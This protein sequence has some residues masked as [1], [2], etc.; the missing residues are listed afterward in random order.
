MEMSRKLMAIALVSAAVAAPAVAQQDT[1]PTVAVLDFNN[2]SYGPN[3]AE[4]DALGKGIA[5][6]LITELAGNANIRVVERDKLQALIAEQNL[7]KE[8]RVS[9]ETMVRIGRM[10]GAH[11]VI[12]GGFITDPKG[13]LALTARAIEVETSR[14][15]HTDRVNDKSDNFIDAIGKLATRMNSGMKLPAMRRLAMGSPGVEKDRATAVPASNPATTPATQV[16]TASP[17]PTQKVP[18]AAIMLYSKALQ[19]KD[20]G[21]NKE[22]V[23]LFKQSLS[24]FPEFAK[25][26]AELAKIEPAT[27][28]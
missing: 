15:E 20:S 13:N 21:N 3:R 7:S 11:H 12:T 27:G 4:Y 8:G 9:D 24:K 19:A 26:K 14:I 23:V 2:G 25:A 28:N 1:R 18:Y 6:F 17:A 10:L 16:A 22:A 5:D